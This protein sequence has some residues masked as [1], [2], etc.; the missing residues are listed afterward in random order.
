MTFEQ[1]V[2]LYLYTHKK[3]SLNLFGTIQLENSIP[4]P[5]I[6]RKEKTVP[7]TGLH[8]IFDPNVPTDEAFV[9][10]YASE[11]GRIRS[12]SQSDIELQLGMARQIVNIGNP[13]EIPGV[14][15]ITKLNNGSLTMLPGYFVI[16]PESGSGRPTPLRER[17][18]STVASKKTEPKESL[19]KISKLKVGNILGI[20]G[21]LAG[22]SVLVW[23]FIAV[24]L[25]MFEKNADDNTV[26][27]ETEASDTVQ[28]APVSITPPQDTQVVN[29]VVLPANTDSLTPLS[30]KAYISKTNQK[31]FADKRLERYKSYG[32][33]AI[34][35]S[36]DSNTYLIYIPLESNLRDTASKRDSLAKFFAYPVR[37]QKN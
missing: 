13:F 17:V 20:A 28:V 3:L 11:K 33:N 7:V 18:S 29:Q 22:V 30:W 21:I 25:P 35:E 6:I 10:F 9:D 23:A 12:L 5:E 19:P 37:L 15:K 1:V 36:P 26:S 8:F 31:D 14:G 16:P 32:H 34:L 2:L 4:E 27:G 24:I